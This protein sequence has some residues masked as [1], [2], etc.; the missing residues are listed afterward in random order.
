MIIRVLD[1]NYFVQQTIP[2]EG[3]LL[4]YVCTNVAEDD[5]KL[6]RIVRIPLDEVTPELIRYLS[7]IFR[8]ER[9][10]ELVQYANERDHLQVVTDCGSAR[11]KSIAERLSESK[12]PLRERL[13]MGEKLLERLILS[14]V[15][16]FFAVSALDE[17]HVRFTDSLD[18]SLTY[19]LEGLLNFQE[20]GMDA[21]I[22]KVRLFLA[23]LFKKEIKDGKLPD[24]EV[25][26]KRIEVGSF[27]ELLPLYTDYRTLA[28]S[29]SAVDEDTLEPK[30]L[31]YRIWEWIKS[32]F[33]FL[34]KLFFVVVILMA[35]T[36]LVLAVRNFLAPTKQMNVY[37]Q[38][39]DLQIRAETEAAQ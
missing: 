7:D 8:K 25:F 30:S 12:V 39:G 32:A 17:T 11:A 38:V 16:A 18:C 33:R 23:G 3:G 24:L 19:E 35:V 9:F 13:A 5:G 34:K 21:V 4:Q 28:E 1:R 22:K 26:L 36:Y 37:S 31:P 15:P 20:A 2:S 27:R 14:D 29:L 10:R 6:Y